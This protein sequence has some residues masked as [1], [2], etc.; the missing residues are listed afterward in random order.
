MS[1]PKFAP[2]PAVDDSRS[3][4]SPPVA[5]KGWTND[6]PGAFDGFQP[7]GEQLGNQGPDQGFALKIAAEYRSRLQLRPGEHSADVVK[8]CLGIALRRASLFS[9]APVVHDLTVAFTIWG[10][11]DANPPADLVAERGVRFS[12]LGHGHYSEARAITD[13]VPE[14]TLRL[15]P[16]QA[17]VAYPAKWKDLVGL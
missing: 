17:A 5:P 10:Y 11:L 4:A 2:T 9:R 13:L 6:R 16:Q 7:S 8:G 15:T 3:Y 12:G 1:A 14:A